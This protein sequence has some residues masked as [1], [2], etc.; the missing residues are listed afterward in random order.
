MVAHSGFVA[1]KSG[2]AQ[3]T[4]NTRTQECRTALATVWERVGEGPPPERD[5]RPLLETADRVD[6]LD[7]A[8]DVLDAPLL[9]RFRHT[10]SEAL[11]VTEAERALSEG[12]L[13]AFGR[14]M[15]ASHES[16]RHDYEVSTPE[17][18]R[19]VAFAREAGAAGARLTGAG[20]G[21]AAL[22]LCEESAE[23]AVRE[24]L[25]GGYYGPRGDTSTEDLLFRAV[26]SG[27]A[28]VTWRS[29]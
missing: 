8:D 24:A 29:G 7:L 23:A 5:Y 18:D 21:G 15:D 20:L 27:G 17:L 13:M 12:D 3:A 4:Y 22:I 1:E 26:P 16:L 11:R 25:A 10:L 2:P 6:L 9:A 19:I 14:I 28:T